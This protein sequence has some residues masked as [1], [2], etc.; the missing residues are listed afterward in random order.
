MVLLRVNDFFEIA[1]PTLS[2]SDISL[3]CFGKLSPKS[4]FG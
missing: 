4:N 2:V 1:N 3:I